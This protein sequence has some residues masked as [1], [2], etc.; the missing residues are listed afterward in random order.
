MKLSGA[1]VF[2]DDN[3]FQQK[4]IYVHDD[5]ISDEYADYG[6]IIDATGCYAIP[7]LID[8][9]FHGALGYDVCDGTLEAF[10][11]VAEYELKNGVT[12]IC[13]ATLTLPAHELKEILAMGA[14]F[15]SAEHEYCAELIGFNMEG[16]FISRVK[17][18]SQNEEYIRKCDAELVREFKEASKGLLKIIGLA[19]EENPGFEEYIRQVKDIVKVAL[20]HTNA[21]YDTAKRAI[22]AGASHVVHLYNA[23]PEFL[24]REP[25]V[26]GA[27]FDSGDVTV[28]LICDGIH[29]HPSSVRNALK[30][31]LPDRIVMISDSLR[32]A[33]MPDGDYE[34]GGLSVEKKGKYCRLKDGGNIA[35][36]VC[37]LYDCL[38]TA[39]KDMEIPL[40]QV[41]RAC[42]INPARCI[43][44]E[45]MYG[46]LQPGKYADIVLLDQ[47]TLA[48]RTVLK[49]GRV[50]YGDGSF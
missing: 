16:P 34:L 32:C 29:I 27:C 37:N 41:V 21:D 47:D 48:V 40:E 4:D 33:G 10:E 39:V 8:I 7:G 6:E 9:H 15:A 5:V 28:E 50:V 43:G 31:L 18:G 1:L 35:G 20:A 25:G 2:G 38:V 24:H 44:A 17:K 26:V 3:R 22:E 11:K 14:D 36:S 30:T 13:P 46:S 12:S 42:T 23:M 19:P 45:D 49:K